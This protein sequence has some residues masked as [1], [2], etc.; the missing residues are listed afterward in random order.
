MDR[1]YTDTPLGRVH[2]VIGEGEHPVILLH[3]GLRSAASFERLM[4]L[5]GPGHRAIA[6]DLPGCGSSDAAPVGVSVRDLAESVV[7]VMDGLEIPKAHVL[8]NHTGATV[9]VEIAAGWPK[10]VDRVIL[11]GYA[12]VADDEERQTELGVRV[13]EM[14][15]ELE[16]APDG[17]HLP[18]WWAWLRQQVEL[19]RLSEGVV[20]SDP[21]T[22]DE[23]GFMKMGLID[24]VRSADTFAA[25]YRAVFEYDSHARLPLIESPTLV[26]DGTGPFEPA[27]VRRAGAVAALVKNCATLTMEGKDGNIIWFDPDA[28]VRVMDEF[29]ETR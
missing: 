24:M 12:L 20:P 13:R 5:L 10:R 17:S 22:A 25:I 23:L 21:F 29:F 7:T 27:I 6:I 11:F 15:R 8:G 16:W 3:Q 28:L 18:R 4:P 19:K 14:E 9:A 2:A 1:R 26:I